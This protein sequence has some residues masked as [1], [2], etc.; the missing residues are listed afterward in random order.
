[1]LCVRMAAATEEYRRIASF[2]G[3]FEALQRYLETESGSRILVSWPPGCFIQLRNLSGLGYFESRFEDVCNKGLY[4]CCGEKLYP[5][6]FVCHRTKQWR[7]RFI[8]LLGETGSVYCYDYDE[9]GVFLVARDVEMLVSEG[10]RNVDGFYGFSDLVLPAIQCDEYIARLVEVQ[11][12]LQAFSRVVEDVGCRMYKVTGHSV[13]DTHFAIYSTEGM[14]I[15]MLTD[16]TSDRDR[17]YMYVMSKSAAQ[18]ACICDIIGV[19]GSVSTENVFV[20]RLFILIDCFGVVYGYNDVFNSVS[21]LADSFEMFIRILGAKATRNYRYSSRKSAV[22]RLEKPPICFHLLQNILPESL[23]DAVDKVFDL[24]ESELC[25]ADRFASFVSF[26]EVVE[27]HNVYEA[28]YK[29]NCVIH[30]N[31][32]SRYFWAQELMALAE[33]SVLVKCVRDHVAARQYFLSLT[34]PSFELLCTKMENEESEDETLAEFIFD[35]PCL[36]CVFRKRWRVFRAGRKE[37]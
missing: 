2:R 16:S 24:K 32:T 35:K 9:D 30:E 21:R 17:L 6:G 15:Q 25:E 1:M 31:A 19:L 28:I 27:R 13:I 7:Y 3:D 37:L 36:K 34:D 20:V 26:K 10:L 14:T 22:M 8:V 23:L 29:I 4:V 12:N 33:S 5:F 18:I 11:H